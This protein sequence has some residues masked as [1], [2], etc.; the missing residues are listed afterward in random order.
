VRA[1]AG[2]CEGGGEVRGECAENALLRRECT[3]AHLCVELIYMHAHNGIV[4][5]CWYV[6]MYVYTY[7]CM[8][9]C[10]YVCI[11]ACKCICMSI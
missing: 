2:A 7:V 3:C 10:M 9:V 4:R 8:Y 5:R 1:W 11:Y 6:C